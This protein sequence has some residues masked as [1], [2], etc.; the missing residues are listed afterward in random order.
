M[1]RQSAALLAPT[2]SPGQGGGTGPGRHPRA[3]PAACRPRGSRRWQPSRPAILHSA[4]GGRSSPAKGQHCLRRASTSGP[5]MPRASPP[6]SGSRR[7]CGSTACRLPDRSSFPSRARTTAIDRIAL[8]LGGT[9]VKGQITLSTAADRRRVE[10]RLDVDEV[11]VAR[12]LS[13]LLDQRLAVAAHGRDRCQRPPER[14]ARRALRC[15]HARWFDG[16]IKLNARRLTLGEGLSLG[17]ASIDITLASGK[18]DVSR[19]EGAAL[20]GRFAAAMRIDKAAA[21][22]M[23]P[24]PSSSRTPASRPWPAPPRGRPARPAR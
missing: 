1:R 15:V 12:L 9:D 24:A 14:L 4:S 20:G 2:A 13:P 17:Q 21:G 16:S 18:V 3:R 6:S 10:A 11:S 7:R 5:P 23:S 22:A 19:I 8:Q